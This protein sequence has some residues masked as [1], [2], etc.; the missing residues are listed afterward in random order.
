VRSFFTGYEDLL[1][2]GDWPA[3]DLVGLR[4]AVSGAHQQYQAANY[5]QVITELPTM[6]QHM[7]RR[8]VDSQAALALDAALRDAFP[9]GQFRG[10]TVAKEE[11][12]T[13]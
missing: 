11:G 8:A 1:H 3:V 4:R 5:G 9:D 7:G 12:Q 10:K 13:P 6:L 2:T